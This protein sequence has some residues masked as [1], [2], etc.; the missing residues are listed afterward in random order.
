MRVAV[1]MR[2]ALDMNDWRPEH[3]MP[4]LPE[5]IEEARLAGFTTGSAGREFG[6]KNRFYRS[7][8]EEVR[9]AYGEPA[10]SIQ[11]G[12]W[13]LVDEIRA[14]LNPNSSKV[15]RKKDDQEET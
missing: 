6:R 12:R 14:I 15:E 8:R 9:V 2:S 7:G 3:Y 4:A 10:E 13:Q 5:E 1:V 11:L